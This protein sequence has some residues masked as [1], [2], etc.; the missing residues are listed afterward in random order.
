MRITDR[1]LAAILGGV[2]PVLKEEVVGLL[3]T[4]A[5]QVETGEQHARARMAVLE[6]RVLELEAQAAATAAPVTDD[7]GFP[8][9]AADR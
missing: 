4:L 2:V 6:A 1:Q 8:H 3:A 5:A 9:A 7:L